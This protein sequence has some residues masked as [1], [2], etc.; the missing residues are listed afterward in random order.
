MYQSAGLTTP[1]CS[2]CFGCYQCLASYCLPSSCLTTAPRPGKNFNPSC[3]CHAWVLIYIIFIMP[4]ELKKA[5]EVQSRDTYHT[6]SFLCFSREKS[7]NKGIASCPWLLQLEVRAQSAPRLLVG[8]NFYVK[9][10]NISTNISTSERTI[11]KLLV[12][13]FR[14]KSFAIVFPGYRSIA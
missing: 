10:T 13:S 11:R 9:T 2:S 8:Y 3:T 4:K 7:F 5:I 14:Q 6:T 1:N 12:I